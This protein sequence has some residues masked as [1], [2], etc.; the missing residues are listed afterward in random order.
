[1]I[2][3]K[4]TI[5]DHLEQVL[6]VS[7]NDP[8]AEILIDAALDSKCV[9]TLTVPQEPECAAAL[10]RLVFGQDL[11]TDKV[12]L[13]DKITEL[14]K[15]TDKLGLK[16]TVHTTLTRT[17]KL[18]YIWQVVEKSEADLVKYSAFGQGSLKAVKQALAELG[19][20]LGMDLSE[21]KDQLPQP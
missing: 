10:G 14:S 3:L 9:M 18:R 21:I 15:T 6:R 8:D 16:T 5:G 11:P 13:T 7:D 4:V 1:M 19:L 2:T 12:V 17:D 20:H